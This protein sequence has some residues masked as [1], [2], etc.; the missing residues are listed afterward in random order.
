MDGGRV[1]RGE[2]VPSAY[3]LTVDERILQGRETAN[4]PNEEAL[5][6]PPVL[7]S[8]LSLSLSLSLSLIALSLSSPCH[9]P[10]LFLLSLSSRRGAHRKF[11]TQVGMLKVKRT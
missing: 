1:Q 4:E 10:A 11:L 8:A 2:P 9:P 5:F 3:L 6:E 7:K